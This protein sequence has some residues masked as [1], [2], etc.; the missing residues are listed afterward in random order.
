MRGN[1]FLL[2]FDGSN[3]LIPKPEKDSIKLKNKKNKAKKNPQ[4]PYR[5]LSLMNLD[6]KISNKILHKSNSKV[7]KKNNMP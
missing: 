5:L 2:I 3:S 6:I 1:T 4:Q 7:Y